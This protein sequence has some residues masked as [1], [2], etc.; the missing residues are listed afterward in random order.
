VPCLLNPSPA[1]RVA[2][3]IVIAGTFRLINALGWSGY[4][5][6]LSI[7]LQLQTDTVKLMSIEILLWWVEFLAGRDRDSLPCG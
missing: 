1:L 7:T 6:C 3:D 4:P 5:R 2:N